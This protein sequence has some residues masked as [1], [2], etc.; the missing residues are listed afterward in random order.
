[1]MLTF[2]AFQQG[3]ACPHQNP[4]ARLVKTGTFCVNVRD[5]P[6]RRDPAAGVLDSPEGGDGGCPDS[7]AEGQG[8]GAVVEDDAHFESVAGNG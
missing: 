7:V 4:A 1:M 3:T 6:R 5:R 2:P 8:F